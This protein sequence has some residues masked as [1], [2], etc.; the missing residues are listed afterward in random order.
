MKKRWTNKE[1]AKEYIS[2]CIREGNLGLSFCAACD[3]VGEKPTTEDK[4]KQF[5]LSII[6]DVFISWRTKDLIDHINLLE[7]AILSA[8]YVENYEYK[9]PDDYIVS[10]EEIL[11]LAKEELSDRQTRRRAYRKHGRK[12]KKN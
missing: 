2:S 11:K 3:F 9:D 6:A 4:I 5:M 7:Y 1:E 12:R 8:E 10:K